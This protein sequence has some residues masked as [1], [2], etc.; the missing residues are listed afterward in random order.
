[1]AIQTVTVEI[2]GSAEIIEFEDDMPFGVFE[3]IIRKSAQSNT[4]N[5][6]DNVQ[7]YRVEIMLNSI[8]KAPFEVTKEGIDSVGYKTIT[9]IG[10]KILEY[11]PLGDYLNQMMKPFNDSPIS[12]PSS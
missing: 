2:K 8:K 1:M 3:K 12:T 9:E 4:E 11:Y 5:L 10:N 6:L 7:Q